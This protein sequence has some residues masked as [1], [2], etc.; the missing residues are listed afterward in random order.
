MALN[1]F[2]TS[3]FMV[4]LMSIVIA[5]R[6][7][8][9]AAMFFVNNDFLKTLAFSLLV[10][11]L[12]QY[13]DLKESPMRYAVRVLYALFLILIAIEPFITDWNGINFLEW[14]MLIP[15]IIVAFLG[16]WVKTTEFGQ[17]YLNYYM[18]VIYYTILSVCLCLIIPALG[19]WWAV[20]IYAV[21]LVLLANVG[22][23]YGN[24]Y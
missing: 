11:N 4:V 15:Y 1:D 12:T 2:L 10:I 19:Y 7:F 6:Q 22:A 8:I 23:N 18:L 9:F 14:L 13:Y 17:K 3:N 20:L 16:T 21:I 5:F 24:E